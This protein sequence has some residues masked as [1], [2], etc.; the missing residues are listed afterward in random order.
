[1]GGIVNKSDAYKLIKAA[2][3]AEQKMRRYVFRGKPA[4]LEHKVAEMD[5]CL[6]ALEVL[7]PEGTTEQAS[8]FDQV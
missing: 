2:L 4:Q 8:L 6:S 1:M 5:R 7:Y 3:L